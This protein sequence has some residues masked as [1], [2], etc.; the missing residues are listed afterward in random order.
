[1]LRDQDLVARLGGD[2]FA[3]GLFDIGQHFEAS[4]VAQKLLATLNEPFLIDGHD[5]RV[6]GSIGISVYPQD[7]QDAET[8]LRLAD[9]AMYRAKQEGG[10][11][12]TSVAFYSQDMNQGMQERMRM[13]PACATRSEQRTAAALPAEIRDGSGRS[14]AP[15][16]WCAGTT[17]SAGAARRIH[18]AGRSDGPGGAGRRMGA[19]SGLRAGAGLER[20]PACRRSAWPSTCRRAN[21]RPRCRAAW[22][23][24]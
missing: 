16:R 17:R 20:W 18:P 14:S 22:P 6:G 10:G 1:V 5:L 11:E 19:G 23:I 12:A 24:R 9:I 7:G 8:L 21:S 3:V 13:E 15:K 2:E 4:M